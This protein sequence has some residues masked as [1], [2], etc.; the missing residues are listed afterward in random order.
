MNTTL[1]YMMVAG[2]AVAF[3]AP[4]LA[5]PP[6]HAPAWGYRNKDKKG[7]HDKD[8]R[9]Y[10][11]YTGVDW[12]DDYGVRSGRCNTDA[13]LT[14]VGG[15]AGAVIGNRVSSPENRTIATIVGAIAGGVIGNKIGD[16]IDSH[17]RACIGH[18]L[19]I[20]S[21]GR[22]VRWSNPTTKVN[23]TLRPLRDLNDGCRQ[24]EHR[25]EEMGRATALTACRNSDASWVIRK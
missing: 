17:D 19:E 2:L 3:I 8:K 24:F 16:S 1:K 13:V 6:S 15:V 21:A 14:A 23:H 20:A 7:S 10:R 4:S 22:A 9:M 5:D 25:T 18:S 11:G 12:V